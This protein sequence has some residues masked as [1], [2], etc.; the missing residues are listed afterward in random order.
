MK[1]KI[2]IRDNVLYEL[3]DKNGDRKLF[4]SHNKLGRFLFT[5]FGLDF[6][7]R[8]FGGMGYSMNIANLVTYTGFAFVTA[9][10]ISDSTEALVSYIALGTGGATTPAETQTTLVAEIAAGGG[11]GRTVAALSRVTTNVLA[12]ND[13]AQLLK[14]FSVTSTATISETGIFNA[15]SAGTMVARQTFTGVP[16]SSGDTFQ[17][18][19]KLQV[20]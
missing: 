13:T 3:F 1:A 5:H 15:S 7:S 12:T 9:R 6:K 14:L 18:T 8:L 10:M 19:W 11:L 20:N 2:P 4:Y 16:V 17:V